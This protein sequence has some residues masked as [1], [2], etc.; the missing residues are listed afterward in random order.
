V[1][2]TAAYELPLSDLHTVASNA[3]LQWVNSDADKVARVQ[4]EIAAEPAPIHV[5]REP[6]PPVA[7]DEGPLMLVE[8]RRDL[9]AMN[10]PFDQP[11][12]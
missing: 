5:P 1:T 12:G 2:P 10:L 6:K 8:T 11:R 9:A 3:G 4:A 7:L